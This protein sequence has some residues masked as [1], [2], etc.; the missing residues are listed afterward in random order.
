MRAEMGGS[1]FL[2]RILI[3]APPKRLSQRKVRYAAVARPCAACN[4]TWDNS[5]IMNPG[6]QSIGL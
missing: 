1:V 5:N 4:A 3:K 2:V 6:P